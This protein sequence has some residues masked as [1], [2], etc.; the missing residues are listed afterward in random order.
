MLTLGLTQALAL[1]ALVLLLVVALWS[2]LGEGGRT[3]P[4]FWAGDPTFLDESGLNDMYL[5]VEG[6]ETGFFEGLLGGARHDAHLLLAT[7]DGIICNQGLTIWANFGRAF[8]RQ[9]TYTCSAALAF[10]EPDAAPWP[11][12]VQLELTPRS[13]T[14]VVSDGEELLGVLVRGAAGY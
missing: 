11:S 14:L 1:G 6:E 9:D 2:H 13:G 10:D 4:G 3:L 5:Q 12:T 7:A 8:R